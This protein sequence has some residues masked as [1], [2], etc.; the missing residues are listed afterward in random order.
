MKHMNQK[1]KRTIK[2]LMHYDTHD[3]TQQRAYHLAARTKADY[4]FDSF[5]DLGYGIDLLS[6]SYTRGSRF[7]KG[8][9]KEIA[10]DFTLRLLPCLGRGSAV[11]G[12]LS[13]LLFSLSF[14]ARLL[15]FVG[16]DDVVWVYHSLWFMRALT[17]LKKLKRFKLILE[18]EEVYGDVICSDKATAREKAFVKLAD[19]YVF[20][21]R[22]LDELLNTE[23][24]PSVISH[25]TYRVTEV[26]PVGFGDGRIHVVYAG[27][28]DVRMGSHSVVEMAKYLDEGYHVHILGGGKPHEIQALKDAVDAAQKD[29]RCALT[30]DGILKGEAY[31]DF[32]RKCHVGLCPHQIDATFNN[33]AFPSKIL[34]YMASGLKVVSVRIPVI[35]ASDV[36][37]H[38]HYYDAHSAESFAR[39][40]SSIDP[41]ASPDSREIIRDLHER[42]HKEL[43]ALLDALET[44]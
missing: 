41:S 9:K 15:F 20:P 21:S 24:K 42:F 33:T 32:I 23:N 36:G 35:E 3:N 7:V 16:K 37:E 29:V 43:G 26:D 14:W 38:L 6:A 44:F 13:S 1:Q 28:L 10:E 27:T 34:S 12:K 18:V 2:C 40:V 8:M 11:K 39:V 4:V 19:A 22:Q 25:G 30:Y 17:L 31:T 5:R